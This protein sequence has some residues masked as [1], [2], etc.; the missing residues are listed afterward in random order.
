M[1]QGKLYTL[2]FAPE[3]T[4]LGGTRKRDLLGTSLAGQTLSGRGKSLVTLL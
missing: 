4:S 2:S 3:N 1:L